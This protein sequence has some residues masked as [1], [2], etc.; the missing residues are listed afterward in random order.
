MLDTTIADSRSFKETD[1][2]PV[3]SWND[4]RDS[5]HLVQFYET[6]EFLLQSLSEYIRNGLLSGDACI[7]VATQTH[8]SGLEQIFRQEGQN[9]SPSYV[10][11]DAR[12]TMSSFM[13]DDQPDAELFKQIIGEKINRAGESGKRVRVYGE[14]VALLWSDSKFDTA[15]RLEQLWNELAKTHQFTLCCAYP[16]GEFDSTADRTLADVCEHHSV[17]VPAESYAQATTVQARLAVITGL[18]QKAKALEREIA[19]RK[20]TEIRLRASEKR[21]KHLKN[22][23]QHQLKKRN[24]L[25]ERE[26][27]ARLEAQTANRMKDEFLANVSHELRTPLTSLFGWARLLRSANLDSKGISRALECIE[28]SV[29][30][31]RQLVEDLLDVSRIVAGKLQLNMTTVA[32]ESLIETSLE[33]FSPPA[34][35]K[36]ISIE[37]YIESDVPQIQGDPI[38]LQ[39]IISNLLSNAIKF[40]PEGGKIGIH[41]RQVQE[42]IS[43][44]VEDTGE[45]IVPEFLPFVFD[46]FRQ[47][48]STT[49]RKHGGLGLG[50][51]I[52]RHLVTLHGGTIHA[53]SEGKGKGSTFSLLLPI[54]PTFE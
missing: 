8:R 53:E 20:Q 44:S 38:R 4:L 47:A 26:Q 43:I 52:A 5:D 46:R 41:L 29:Q 37:I 16:I 3:Q 2:L 11:L 24:E 40:T 50:L 9:F 32:V 42:K 35:L 15:I 30:T 17:V 31:Q 19:E 21:H 6:D 25:L 22:Q 13:I 28:R 54:D 7:I 23:L 18:Q 33:I 49:T 10:A 51:T 1:F 39:Q 27:A 12:E 34:V 36:N 14:M 48:D 45:G